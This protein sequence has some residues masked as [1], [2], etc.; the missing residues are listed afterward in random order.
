MDET[1]SVLC[2]VGTY[3]IKSVESM[4]SDTTVLDRCQTNSHTNKEKDKTVT[5][6]M[7]LKYEVTK[8]YG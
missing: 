5:F 7:T 1:G 6:H 2:P 8:K 3:G 4:G